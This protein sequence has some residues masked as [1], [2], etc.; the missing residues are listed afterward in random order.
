MENE[1]VSMDDTKKKLMD[2][3][4]L[5]ASWCQFWRVVWLV[6]L[7]KKAL[8]RLKMLDDLMGG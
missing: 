2:W 6:E 8:N 5:R 7:N 1:A 3:Y 4:I